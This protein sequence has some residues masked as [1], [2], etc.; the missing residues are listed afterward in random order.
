MALLLDTGAFYAAADQRDRWH[1]PVRR[2]LEAARE[3]LLTPATVLTETCYLLREA[4]GP[5]A[6]R[7][8][9]R[10][11]GTGRYGLVHLTPPDTLRAAE[12]LEKY[13]DLRLDFVDASLVAVAER[14]Q[15]TRIATTDRRDFSLI[16]PAHCERFDILP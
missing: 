2:L 11:I 6:E 1:L 5:G 7:K 10:D 14:L 12:L 4:L 9:L 15:I 16:R 3:P 8:F 13:E